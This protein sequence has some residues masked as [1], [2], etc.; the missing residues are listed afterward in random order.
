L[1]CFG[2]FPKATKAFLT[3]LLEDAA[4]QQAMA[5]DGL[6]NATQV[7][8]EYKSWW[9]KEQE[10]SSKVM[11][12]Q[13]QSS[14]YQEIQVLI[15]GRMHYSLAPTMMSVGQKIVLKQKKM[16]IKTRQSPQ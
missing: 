15:T 16:T 4:I 7:E 12:T 2:V 3:T 5:S 8:Q 11:Q 9:K 14:E 13:H 1:P 6:S 10:L